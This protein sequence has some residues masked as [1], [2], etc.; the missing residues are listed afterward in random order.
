MNDILAKDSC[1]CITYGEV[2]ITIQVLPGDEN[3]LRVISRLSVS[4]SRRTDEHKSVD[5][6]ELSRNE[7]QWSGHKHM[8]LLNTFIF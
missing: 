4:F 7:M 8:H 1:T 3:K 6:R 5:E 2:E